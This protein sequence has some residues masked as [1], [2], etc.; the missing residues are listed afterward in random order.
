MA[1]CLSSAF[2][3]NEAIA[4]ILG[5]LLNAI[6]VILVVTASSTE[7]KKYGRLLLGNAVVDVGFLFV[8]YLIEI[9]SGNRCI[10]SM[11]NVT[12]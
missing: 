5:L 10:L 12:T 7:L 6:L 3:L 4:A 8:S 1:E 9:V 11:R 2:R